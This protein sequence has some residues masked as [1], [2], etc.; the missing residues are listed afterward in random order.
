MKKPKP[1]IPWLPKPDRPRAEL[2]AAKKTI[3]R[4]Q[5]IGVVAFWCGVIAA[6]VLVLV[7]WEVVGK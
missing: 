7:I 5:G 6:L 4:L 2:R 1:L 3:A